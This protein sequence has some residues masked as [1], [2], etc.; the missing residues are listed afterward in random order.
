[1]PL[2]LSVC[3]L[4]EIIIE[5]L[6]ILHNDP[7]PSTIHIPS[8]EWIRL[9]FCPTNA[10]TTRSIQHTGRFNVKFKVQGRLL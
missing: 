2:A 6:K 8:E 9:Q 10:T 1:M 3:D 7:L 4:R 5:R